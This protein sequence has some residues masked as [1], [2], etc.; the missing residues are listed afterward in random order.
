MRG[1]WRTLVWKYLVL[2]ENSGWAQTSA[3]EGCQ[4]VRAD[5]YMQVN[6]ERLTRRENSKK[7]YLC[8]LRSTVVDVG[9]RFDRSSGLLDVP[10]CPPPTAST[11]RRARST[12][13]IWMR[14][15]LMFLHNHSSSFE[16]VNCKVSA[17]W[18][19]RLCMLQLG[20]QGSFLKVLFVW[21]M[22]VERNTSQQLNPLYL[23]WYIMRPEQSLVGRQQCRLYH[24][25]EYKAQRL[26]N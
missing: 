6:R 25:W 4:L 8:T 22:A 21:W 26:W 9:F 13:L 3:K 17:M 16:V 15:D 10:K 24:R 2:Q 14:A 20:I 23:M 7:I 1:F 11:W 12:Q 18:I 19:T 5:S